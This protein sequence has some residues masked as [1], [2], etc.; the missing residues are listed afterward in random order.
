M[1][2]LLNILKEIR[3][4]VDFENN[5]ALIDNNI[6]DSFDIIALVG[7]INEEFEIDIGAEHLLPEH[8][9]SPQAMMNLII[10]LQEEAQ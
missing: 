9:N 4:D 6:L 1:K 10:S 5:T 7:A 2:E 3:Q 8:F